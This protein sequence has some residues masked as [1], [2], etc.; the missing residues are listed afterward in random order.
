[1]TD[2]K[3]AVAWVR[4]TLAACLACLVLCLCGVLSIAS[5]FAALTIGFF[6]LLVGF[7]AEV[8]ARAEARQF[9]RRK[10]DRKP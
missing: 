5:M 9:R 6:L 1:M 8:V 7:A 10:G 4:V 3:F 2:L